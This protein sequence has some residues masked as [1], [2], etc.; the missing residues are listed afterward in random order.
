[1]EPVGPVLDSSRSPKNSAH[2]VMT[3]VHI[4]SPLQK[5]CMCVVHMHA[6]SKS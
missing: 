4:S 3:W 5:P 2:V 6:M 1:M